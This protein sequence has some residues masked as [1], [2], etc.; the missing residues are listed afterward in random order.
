M[1]RYVQNFHLYSSTCL[2]P[3]LSKEATI[4]SGTKPLIPIP[5][6]FVAS[7]RTYHYTNNLMTQ[8]YR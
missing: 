8:G 6:Q 3:N 5:N 2:D 4:Y 7:E 1:P